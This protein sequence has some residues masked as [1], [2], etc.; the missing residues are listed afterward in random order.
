MLGVKCA[1]VCVVPSE[2]AENGNCGQMDCYLINPCDAEFDLAKIK[3]YLH[4]LW[5]FNTEMV[6]VVEILPPVAPFT[7]MD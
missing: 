3:I 7:N 2:T 4:H 5:L 6:Q 1:A